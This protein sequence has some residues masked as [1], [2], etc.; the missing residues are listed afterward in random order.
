[1]IIVLARR[2]DVGVTVVGVKGSCAIMRR[3]GHRVG[4]GIRMAGRTGMDVGICDDRV[5]GFTRQRVM[6]G[7][8]MQAI[9]VRGHR[10]AERDE[11]EQTHDPALHP[12]SHGQRPSLVLVRSSMITI[13]TSQ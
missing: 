10:R 11:S 3:S 4:R 8:G 5:N 2:M 13:I 12:A 7:A 6:V 9:R 1:M